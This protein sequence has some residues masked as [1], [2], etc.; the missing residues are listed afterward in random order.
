MVHG[1]R[2]VTVNTQVVRAFDLW[3]PKD[4]RQRVLWPTVVRLS[5]DYF[6]SL[7]KHAVPLDEHAIRALANN[8]M[9]LDAYAWLAQRLH[10]IAAGKPQFVSWVALKEQFGWHYGRVRDFRRVFLATLRKVK[11]VYPTAKLDEVLGSSGQPE[12]LQLLHSP[13]PVERT[14]A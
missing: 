8:A 5:T 14:I 2:P 4:E 12:G 10:R 13:S 6:E 9:A 11:A 1:A 3:F 7:T